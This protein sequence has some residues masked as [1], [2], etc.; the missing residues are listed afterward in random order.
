[1]LTPH[2]GEPRDAPRDASRSR[3][4]RE[5]PVYR[6]GELLPPDHGERRG[7]QSRWGLQPSGT[8]SLPPKSRSLSSLR[9]HP[10]SELGTA[11][12]GSVHEAHWRQV[13]EKT[14]SRLVSLLPE[15]TRKRPRFLYPGLLVSRDL[16]HRGS[17]TCYP[18]ESYSPPAK[19]NLTCALCPRSSCGSRCHGCRVWLRRSYPCRS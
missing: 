17:S 13:E 11:E 18:T 14:D 12:G 8:A 9:P 2:Q 4:R 6:R 19:A 1:M 3:R 15:L 16:C 7:G 10:E 5:A